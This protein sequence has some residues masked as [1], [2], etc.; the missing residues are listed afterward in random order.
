MADNW[1]DLFGP[2]WTVLFDLDDTLVITYPI[3]DIKNEARRFGNWSEVYSAFNQTVLPTGTK[4]LI[5][6]L[7]MR[8]TIGVI[9]SSPRNYAERL[10]SFHQLNI[11]VITAYH[12]TNKHKP[13]PEPI[14]HAINKLKVNQRK[15]IYVG[16]NEDDAAASISAGAIPVLI[17]RDRKFFGTALA[18]RIVEKGGYLAPDWGILLDSLKYITKIDH[19]LTFITSDDG[20]RKIFFSEKGLLKLMKIDEFAGYNVFYRYT[21]FPKYEKA[22]GRD[23]ASKRIL[24]MKAFNN[25]AI[26]YFTEGFIECLN[27]ESDFV[28]TVIPS[29][30][31]GLNHSGIRIVAGYLD[32]EGKAIDGTTCLFRKVSIPKSSWWGSVRDYRIQYDSL[33]VHNVDI[34]HGR[35]VLVLD[36]VCTTGSTIKA[37]IDKLK[38][39]GANHVFG[40]VIGRTRK[41]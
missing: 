37:A 18:K 9:T 24:E 16:D 22:H 11:P 12:D 38:E 31:Q 7:S 13:N 33:E 25:E 1:A 21:Y 39:A 34:V 28:I 35:N 4:Q 8:H 23:F 41:K 26:A 2:E 17:D 30:R 10:L 15:T 19:N 5:E 36:D 40:L 27:L 20:G 6:F 3:D 14:I 29:H 32:G